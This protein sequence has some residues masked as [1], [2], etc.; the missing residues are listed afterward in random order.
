MWNKNSMTATV[1]VTV[2]SF[3]ALGARLFDDPW[4]SGAWHLERQEWRQVTDASGCE[5]DVTRLLISNDVGPL[6]WAVFC[7]AVDAE[8]KKTLVVFD[9]DHQHHNA[10]RVNFNSAMT[11]DHFAQWREFVEQ[12]LDQKGP[13][14]FARLT[15]MYLEDVRYDLLARIEEEAQLA[16]CDGVLM[17]VAS[18]SN[19][20][21]NLY[22]QQGYVAV[23]S[24][25]GVQ[26][27]FKPLG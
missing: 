21:E 10:I 17:V 2:L 14:P 26:L 5:R 22:K 27:M 24:E 18:A 13:V 16:D 3:S 12:E 1:V 19:E 7:L 8:G 4:E 23:P 20:F 6:C 11:S 9:A 15:D 25:D